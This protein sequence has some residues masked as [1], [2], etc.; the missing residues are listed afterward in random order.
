MY[1][2]SVVAAE[3]TTSR[4]A[5]CSRKRDCARASPR[6]RSTR[7]RPCSTSPTPARVAG[8]RGTGEPGRRRD[9][10]RSAV[11]GARRR[12]CSPPTSCAARSRR[13]P[14]SQPASSIERAQCST[15]CR[16]TAK[17][18]RDARSCKSS[19]SSARATRKRRI[20]YRAGRRCRG[21]QGSE[22]TSSG[23]QQ[24]S[25][26]PAIRP[27]RRSI[28]SVAAL[29]QDGAASHVSLGRVELLRG[30]RRRRAPTIR[31]RAADGA[32]PP[33]ASIA[34]AQLL[35]SHG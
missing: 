1:L 22:H 34:L 23:R 32:R 7:S 19:R 17:S 21:T 2:S 15:A 25:R 4:R 35:A 24:S 31:A 6:T 13:R 14:T 8:A 3:P 12:S 11:P 28:C 20:D 30:Q 18:R 5:A 33:R 29:T 10:F 16:R 9:C 27:R 26:R